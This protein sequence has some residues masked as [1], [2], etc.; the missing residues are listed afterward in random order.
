MTTYV[1]SKFDAENDP[2]RPKL[3][4]EIEYKGQKYKIVEVEAAMASELMKSMMAGK[5]PDLR[6]HHELLFREHPTRPAVQWACWVDK[7]L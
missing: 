6:G 5:G 1:A 4:E 7:A 3:G 2:S